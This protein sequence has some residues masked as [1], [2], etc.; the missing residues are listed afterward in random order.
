MEDVEI[1]RLVQVSSRAEIAQQC[2]ISVV[3]KAL[4][5]QN[6]VLAQKWASLFYF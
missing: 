5:Y 3:G 1:A 6:V 2:Q 4:W